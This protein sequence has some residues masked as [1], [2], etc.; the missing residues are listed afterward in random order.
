MG[1]QLWHGLKEAIS[2]C[3]MA[4]QQQQQAQPYRYEPTLTVL[5]A[6]REELLFCLL[7]EAALPGKIK[8]TYPISIYLSDII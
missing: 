4:I 7:E 2:V 5:N 1:G 6:G 3:I 8:H